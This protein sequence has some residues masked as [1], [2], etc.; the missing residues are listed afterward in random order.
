[1]SQTPPPP[2]P[3]GSDQPP[4]E[5]PPPPPPSGSD[6]SFESYTSSAPPPPPPMDAAPPPPPPSSDQPTYQPPPPPPPVAPP[7]TQPPAPYPT[8]SA[9]PPPVA[10][11]PPGAAYP[12]PQAYSGAGQPADLVPRFIAK[13]IDGVVMLGINLVVGAVVVVGLNGGFLRG[14]FSTLLTTALTLGYYSFLESSRGQT[15]GKM[16]MG[17]KVQ[18]LAGQNPTM[19]EALK[20]N[21]YFALALI[22]ILPFLGGFIAGLASIAAVIYIAVTINGDTPLHRG[23]HDKFGGTQVITTR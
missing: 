21:A 3:P 18:N 14:V 11:Y 6:P 19:E 22:G 17:L 1:M 15:V 5:P 20:R 4:Y 8:G 9:Y 12:V 7:A 13:L 16:V 23:W 10:P 2:P